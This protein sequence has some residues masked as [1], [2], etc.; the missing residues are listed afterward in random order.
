MEITRVWAMPNA[1]TFQVKPIGNF[2]RKYLENSKYSIDPFARNCEFATVRNDLNTLT[3]A[4]HH[5]DALEFLR[6]MKSLGR[7]FDLGIFDPPYSPRQISEVYQQIGRKTT[8][9]DTSKSWGSWRDALSENIEVGGVVLSFG[10]N[11]CGMG[12]KRGFEIVEILM[13]CHG[14]NHNDTIC[15]AEIKKSNPKLM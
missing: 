2:V 6:Y 5:M 11:S 13:V 15:T 1:D 7:L 9:Q 3:A 14:G 8:T 10:W 12:M 4:T